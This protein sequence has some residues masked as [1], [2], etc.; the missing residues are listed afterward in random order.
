[1]SKGIGKRKKIF[2]KFV[3]QL[4]I[5]NENNLLANFEGHEEGVY[6]CPIC[7]NKFSK[8]D[9]SGNSTNM[10]TLEDAPP[11]ALGGKANTL[12]CKK[13]N[14]KCGYEI[15]FHLIERLIELDNRSFL[16]NTGSKVTLTHNG[17][18]VH[19]EVCVDSIGDINSFCV[20]RLNYV[21]NI[22]NIVFEEWT[23]F[24]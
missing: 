2:D 1:M 8:K 12:T 23:K 16:P 14:N 22:S 21:R 18:K 19:G 17:L 11:K 10:L 5:L 20:L 4:K 3:N 13:C 24:L 15:D 7:L 9:L 6:I